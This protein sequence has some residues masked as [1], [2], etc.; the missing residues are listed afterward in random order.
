MTRELPVYVAHWNGYCHDFDGLEKKEIM[1]KTSFGHKQTSHNAKGE[2]RLIDG[3]LRSREAQRP[4]FAKRIAESENSVSAKPYRHIENEMSSSQRSSDP[5][6]EFH[7]SEK[8][9]PPQ[10]RT[11]RS[12]SH[13]SKRA[14]DKNSGI[15]GRDASGKKHVRK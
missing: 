10:L 14:K 1:S 8:P 9:P 5:H 7:D 2:K 11:T 6:D 4:E 15:K 12:T 3:N 13:R